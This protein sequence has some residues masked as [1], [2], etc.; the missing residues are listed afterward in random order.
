MSDFNVTVVGG[1]SVRLPTANTWCENDIIITATGG[2]SGGNGILPVGYTIVPS[3]KFTGKQAVDTGIICNQNT[4]IIAVF[5]VDY[6][7]SAYIYGVTN[8]TNTASITAYRS[9]SGGYWRFG[10][11]RISLTTPVDEEIV[12]GI[13]QN[14][15]RILRGNTASTYSTVNDF[16]AERTLVLGGR[17]VTDNTIEESTLLIGKI[18]SLEIYNGDNLVLKFIP[19]KNAEGICGFWDT[20]SEKF[21]VSM[22]NTPLEED[23]L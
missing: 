10:N 22:T 5:T 1:K 4:E 23:Y 12:W 7:I 6:D 3:I 9:T 15:K 13:K 14:K 21:F 19:C 11:Q 17:K 18:I 16:T 2:T 8:D 20:V